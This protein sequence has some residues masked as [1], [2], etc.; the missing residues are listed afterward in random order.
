MFRHL[1][2]QRRIVSNNLV[3]A[4][5]R[6]GFFCLIPAVERLDRV[7]LNLLNNQRTNRGAGFGI[8]Y[9]LNTETNVTKKPRQLIAKVIM[10]RRI[11]VPA[12]NLRRIISKQHHTIV[13]LVVYRVPQTLHAA[14][15]S[16]F[17]INRSTSVRHARIVEYSLNLVP[18]RQNPH[19][20]TE[21]VRANLLA[22]QR[23][24]VTLNAKRP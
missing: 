17:R 11:Y 7:R 9:L 23:L 18:W 6:I 10:R 5:N 19:H 2:W 1:S 14:K 3:N 21:L 24:Q 15:T 13:L 8:Q 20:I 4:R 22:A 12:I 16:G